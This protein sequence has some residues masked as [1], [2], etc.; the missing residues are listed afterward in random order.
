MGGYILDENDKFPWGEFIAA[1]IVTTMIIW[2][3]GLTIAAIIRYI[4]FRKKINKWRAR[5]IIFILFL[6]YFT[7]LN[8]LSGM[9]YH[10]SIS[11]FIMLSVSY[12]I[13]T[14]PAKSIISKD[15]IKS[16]NVEA[17]T[18]ENSDDST[19]GHNAYLKGLQH[20]SD[21]NDKQA[22][23]SFLKAIKYGYTDGVFELLGL[24]YQ[25]E[26]NQEAAIRYLDTAIKENLDDCN[27]LFCRANSK[28]AFNDPRG[29]IKDLECAIYLANQNH[30]INRTYDEGA[31]ELGYDNLA[32]LY[33][34]ALIN[35]KTEFKNKERRTVLKERVEHARKAAYEKPQAPS[36]ECY[37]Q[38]QEELQSENRKQGLWAKVFS[39]ADGDKTIASARYIKLRAKQFHEGK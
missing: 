4:I 18:T 31:N 16:K 38:A 26:G 22:I 11:L 13:L 7:T 15:I 10:P 5:I 32:S 9:T 14:K 29:A 17:Q 1:S 12:Y 25:S 35:F 3:I 30:I 19:L 34:M 28:W 8:I 37:A 27:L 36:E 20:H 2:A 6:T 23:D 33:N 24:S 21:K 39:G